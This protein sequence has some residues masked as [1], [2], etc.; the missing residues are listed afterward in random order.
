MEEFRS[1]LTTLRESFAEWRETGQ[2]GEHQ[3]GDVV[4]MSNAGVAQLA[5]DTWG[6]RRRVRP[7][8]F[9][10]V[11]DSGVEDDDAAAVGS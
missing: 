9:W 6:E 1:D 7:V 5:V 4:V 11:N 2:I 3:R 10:Y 8:T